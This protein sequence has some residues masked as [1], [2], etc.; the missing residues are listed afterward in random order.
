MRVGRDAGTLLL[1]DFD[2]GG[3]A[4]LIWFAGGDCGGGG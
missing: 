1:G 2:I 4:K 3:G